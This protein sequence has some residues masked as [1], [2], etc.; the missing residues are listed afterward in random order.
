MKL[1][2][3]IAKSPVKNEPAYK[4]PEKKAEAVPPV[5]ERIKTPVQVDRVPTIRV[6]SARVPST[7]VKTPVQIESKT[8]NLVKNLAAPFKF[9]NAYLDLKPDNKHLDNETL[10]L[11]QKVLDKKPNFTNNYVNFNRPE[12]FAAQWTKQQ[13]SPVP[14]EAVSPQKQ[15][16]VVPAVPKK[17]EYIETD[18]DVS[19]FD[20]NRVMPA[21]KA[22]VI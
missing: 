8:S 1:W 21:P 14:V 10:Q 9:K 20:E 6:P 5:I 16:E 4:M 17:P 18:L 12:T 2:N 7:R 15:P 3:E 11:L 13:Q 22:K 19:K